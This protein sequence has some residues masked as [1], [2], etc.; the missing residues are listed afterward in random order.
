[1]D[2][3]KIIEEVKKQ[4]TELRFEHFSNADAYELGTILY[5]LAKERELPVAIQI[6][7]NHQIIYHAALEGTVQDNDEWLARKARLVNRMGKSSYLI[8][9]ELAKDGVSLDEAHGLNLKEYAAHGGCFPIFVKGTGMIGTVAVSGL[10]QSKD[11]ELVIEGIKKY[12]GKLAKGE[13]VE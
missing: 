1:M 5:N 3:E 12:L 8:G 11:H 6:T 13:K 9:R 4:E 10:E 2:L 7:K